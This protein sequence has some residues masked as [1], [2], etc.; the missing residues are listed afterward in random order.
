MLYF[1]RAARTDKGVS[2]A[3][4]TLSIKLPAD[5]VAKIPAVN[6]KLPDEIR[7]IHA[8][9]TTKYF[10]SKNFCDARTYSYM[11]PTYA[12]CP[13][14]VTT[15]ESYRIT[16]E[17]VAELNKILEYYKGT[18]NFHNFTSQKLPTD[19]SAQRFI[20]SMECSQAFMK[21]DL[22]FVVVRVKGQSFM[23]HQIRKMIGLAI[24]IM[25]GFANLDTL[26]NCYGKLRIDIPKAPGLGL[27]LEQ[28][29]YTK[30]NS[31]FGGDG[32]HEP[33]DWEESAKAIE[34]FKTSKIYPVMIETEKKERSMLSWLETL[35]V[36]TYDVREAGPHVQNSNK[37]A[38]AAR[39]NNPFSDAA[40]LAKTAIEQKKAEDDEKKSDSKADEI[41]PESI[42]A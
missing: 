20:I 31:K 16:P 15:D 39:R 21:D 10:D 28:V 19:P 42:K 36:H 27:M 18:H 11:M 32:I 12:L 1:Q 9:R 35:A 5:F 25:R 22:E 17:I 29:H 40:H 14:A 4:Q 23:L 38:A 3:K 7:V 30:Y 8:I 41:D 34:E 2:A 13:P 6:E 33:V 26:K 24:A 37:D